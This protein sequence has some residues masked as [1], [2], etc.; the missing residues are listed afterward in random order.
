[1][2]PN[3]VITGFPKCGTT[4]LF[5]WLA[6]HPQVTGSTVKEASFF[7]D[8]GTHSFRTDANFRDHG[9]AAY[10]AFF[11]AR[12]DAKIVVEATPQYAYQATALAE[13]PK[14]PTAPKLIFLVRNPADQ[15]LSLYTYYKSNFNFFDPSISFAEFLDLAKRKDNKIGKN[16]LLLNAL[17]YC[18]YEH[19]L[20]RW[21][22]QV[23]S[24]RMLVYI[25]EDMKKDKRRFMKSVAARLGISSSF[26]DNYA[27]PVE[28]Y[29][30]QLKSYQLHQLNIRLRKLLPIP[31]RSGLWRGLRA[32]YRKLNT[33]PHDKSMP[34]EDH[35]AFNAFNEQWSPRYRALVRRYGLLP[36]VEKDAPADVGARD[37]S[38]SR[39]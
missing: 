31:Q 25:F 19:Y 8:P 18:D 29:S 4:S 34:T 2:L 9:L 24:E 15:V 12:S 32:L 16:E 3:V 26:Y 28:N 7:V 21:E 6:D 1:M 37:L 14:L 35:N 23:G 39:R 27:F 13:L 5:T 22:S 10:E 17:T 20:R 36:A 38:F 33:R 30:Y 11:P